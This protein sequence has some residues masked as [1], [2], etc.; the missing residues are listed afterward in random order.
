MSRLRILVLA[1]DCNP[2]SVCGPLISY[3]RSEALAQLHDVTLA[4]RSPYE[5]PVRG[6][7]VPFRTIEVVRMPLLER[8]Y[9]W[10]LRRIFDNDFRNQAWTAFGYPFSV[11]FERIAWRQMRNRIIAG[12]FDAVL[13]LSPITVVLPSP[14]GLAQPS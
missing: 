13:R 4:I 5:D 1:P 2:D 14:F 3:S 11:A 12:E 7:Q 9:S 8:V 10:S 6:R